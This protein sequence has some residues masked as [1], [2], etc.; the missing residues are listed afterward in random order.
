M[1]LPRRLVWAALVLAV[2]LPLL[3]GVP[4]VRAASVAH[5]LSVPALHP[6]VQAEAETSPAATHLETEAPT[7]QIGDDTRLRTADVPS[8]GTFTAARVRT[9]A[10]AQPKVHTYAVLVE[11]TIPLQADDVAREIHAALTD[12]RGWQGWQGHGFQLVASVR[13][14]DMVIKVSTGPTTDTLCAP[15]TTQ[16]TWSCRNGTTVVVN[17]NRWAYGTPTFAGFSLA[18]YHAYLLN[19]EV[20]HWLGHGHRTCPGAG[21]PA[22][23]MLQQSIGLGGCR[24]NVW[25][26]DSNYR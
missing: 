22:P 17:Y 24:A 11:S 19:H 15:L 21:R 3:A 5:A 7:A 9:D 4:A 26:A 1:A 25:P 13:E 14:A 8:S 20:G 12:P 16:Q 6:L 2:V 10:P 23:I 18:D